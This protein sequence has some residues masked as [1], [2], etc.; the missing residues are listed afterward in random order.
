[1]LMAG[2]LS[3]GVSS[4]AGWSRGAEGEGG[5]DAAEGVAEQVPGPHRA[6]TGGDDVEVAGGVRL[7]KVVGIVS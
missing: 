3:D 4:A 2:A 5:V 1:M 7:L 6:A